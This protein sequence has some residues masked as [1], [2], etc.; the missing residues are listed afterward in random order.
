M[1]NQIIKPDQL[2]VFI[3]ETTE[4]SYDENRNWVNRK[5]DL[6]FIS[7]LD[8]KNQ[9][10]KEKSI[11]NWLGISYNRSGKSEQELL[12]EQVMI[13]ENQLLSGYK[14]AQVKQRSSSWFGSGRHVW[15][16]EHPLGFEFEISSEN[17]FA[18]LENCTFQDGEIKEKCVLAFSGAYMSLIS[19]NSELYQ[20]TFLNQAR[21]NSEVKESDL[22][23]GQKVVLK[24]GT[25]GIYYGRHKACLLTKCYKF[26][27]K[28]RSFIKVLKGKNGKTYSTPQIYH[29]ANLKTAYAFD[30]EIDLTE[31]QTINE[32]N[33]VISK[34]TDSYKMKGVLIATNSLYALSGNQNVLGVWHKNEKPKL[35][36]IFGELS[37]TDYIEKFNFPTR[38]TVLGN[39]SYSV[40]LIV[41]SLSDFLQNGD[42][43]FSCN[44]RN[45]RGSVLN[46]TISIYGYDYKVESDSKKYHFETDWNYYRYRESINLNPKN[47]KFLSITTPAGE[48]YIK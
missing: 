38:S 20:Q 43:Y 9:L 26:E 25:E 39:K 33:E 42:Y 32:I 8:N 15:R 47:H 30:K 41:K 17:L 40:P 3:K 48:F 13:V 10:K 19:E 27:I 7:Y 12:D 34:K 14:L 5:V 44:Y 6:A 46:E 45:S 11:K 2:Q 4:G 29:L 28:L 16:V 18:L 31:Q 36:D 23:V 22:E 24:D 35:E 37:I 21:M 1:N